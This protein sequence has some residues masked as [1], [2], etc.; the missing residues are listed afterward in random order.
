MKYTKQ[1]LTFK[2]QVELLMSRGLIVKDREAAEKALSSISYYRFSA[3]S[4]PFQTNKDKFKA[5]TT[6]E[7]IS[8]LYEFDH[9]LLLLKLSRCEM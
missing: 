8:R 3:Y 4:L 2:K 6:I 5:K 9:N 1:H 7:Q